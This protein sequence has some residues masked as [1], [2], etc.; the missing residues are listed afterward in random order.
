M[1]ET[2]LR[3]HFFKNIAALS[4]G[5]LATSIIPGGVS[6]QTQSP[7]ECEAGVIAAGGPMCSAD[8]S[9]RPRVTLWFCAWAITSSSN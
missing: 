4:A 5:A 1:D 7:A 8:T 3:R 2:Y 6:A 9:E